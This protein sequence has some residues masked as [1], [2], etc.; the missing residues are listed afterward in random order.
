MA[1]PHGGARSAC[2]S[3]GVEKTGLWPCDGER[4]ALICSWACHLRNDYGP[5]MVN[6][7]DRVTLRFAG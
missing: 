5:L 4:A 7:V 3:A 6:R 1:L 2:E